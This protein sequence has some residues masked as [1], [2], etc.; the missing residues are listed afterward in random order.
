MSTDSVVHI[1]DNEAVRKSLAFVLSAAQVSVR[2][3]E[4]AV[5]LLAN[6]ERV[7]RGCI[8]TDLRMPE[9]EGLSW[10]GE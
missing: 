1:V 5:A 6:I 4:T 7:D 10:S 8:V 3:Y 2:S 9:I